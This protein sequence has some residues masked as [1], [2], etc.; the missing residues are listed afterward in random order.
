MSISKE[1]FGFL[2]PFFAFN[3]ERWTLNLWTVTTEELDGIELRK[4]R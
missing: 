3:P 4:K 1:H 2:M